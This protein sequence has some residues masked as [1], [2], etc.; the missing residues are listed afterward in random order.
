MAGS[1]QKNFFS[2]VCTFLFAGICPNS[3]AAE[4]SGTPEELRG[5]LRSETRTVTI[6]DEAT[7]LAYSD[8][9]KVT[10]V[11]STKAKML[12]DAMR[13][14]NEIRDS[15][16][17]T[18][19]DGGVESDDIQSSK[20]SASPQFGWFGSAPNSFEVMNTLV[21]TVD[22]ES[23]FRRIAQISDQEDSVRFGGAE[24]EHSQ[25]EVYEDRVRDKAMEAVM[26][27]RAYFE[28]K[29]GLKL[30][31]LT[32]SFSDMEFTGDNGFGYALEEIVVTGSRSTSSLGAV[33]PAIS[34]SFDEIEYRVTVEVTFEVESQDQSG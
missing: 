32:F 11:V 4:L 1:I 16:V 5:Y 6:R 34:S 25:K 28:E 24:F 14:N 22:S 19:V 18:L 12:A 10:L 13:E 27:D 7:E 2:A 33:Q 3:L 26:Q 21:V 8:I 31:P 29:L 30:R 20:Y 15:I 23:A 9:A 17:R